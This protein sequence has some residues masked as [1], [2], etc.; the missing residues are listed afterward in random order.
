MFL[1]AI[2]RAE[3]NERRA[4]LLDA[5]IAAVTDEKGFDSALR[6]LGDREQ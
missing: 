5:R 2:A 3:R 6:N 1:A 4:R